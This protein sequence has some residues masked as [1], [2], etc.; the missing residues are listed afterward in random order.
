MTVS[1]LYTTRDE[2]QPFFWDIVF[3]WE[4]I[5]ARE[6]NI[7][8]VHI[9]K[10]YNDIY[11]PSLIRKVLNRLG[12]YPL[13]DRLLPKGETFLAF[14]IGPPGVYS[15]HSGL[16]V[17]SLIIDFWKHEDVDRF[18]RIFSHSRAVFV[19]SRE[20]Y[21]YLKDRGVKL[22]LFFLPLS[23]PD[24]YLNADL[25]GVRDIDVIQIGRQNSQLTNFMTQLMKD[26][27]EIHYVW[28]EGKSGSNRMVSNQ[29]GA[30]GELSSR[31]AFMSLLSRSKVSLLSAPGM[32][33]DL[34]R[35]GGFS[36]VTPRFLESAACGCQLI[37]IF[38]DNADFREWKISEI[39]RT[40]AGYAEF[41]SLVLE[42]LGLYY[43]RKYPAFLDRNISSKRARELK[44]ILQAL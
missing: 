33:N 6:L 27:P 18:E 42:S 39:C 41:K 38:P 4:D 21:I 34:E 5:F 16:N 26:H 19:S 25:Q 9:G 7:P 23:L 2:R 32:D 24:H 30:L 20:V 12:Y 31:D 3:E 43:P 17:I 35:T 40:F 36:P 13:R 11:K 10:R 28:A 15:F 44:Q 37:G 8:L 14:H 29:R 22:N 1:G